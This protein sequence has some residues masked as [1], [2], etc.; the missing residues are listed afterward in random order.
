MK[1]DEIPPLLALASLL[2]LSAC[3]GDA[4]TPPD[5]SEPPTNGEGLEWV[6]RPNPVLAPSSSW[7]GLWVANASIIRSDGTFRM[8]HGGSDNESL[9]DPISIGY[10]TS[11]DGV[12]WTR[13]GDAPVLAPRSGM[14]D[15]THVQRPFV[16]SDGD[17][18][19]M[20]Y[21]GGSHPG[22]HDIGYATSTDG[23]VWNRRA[24]PVL[25]RGAATEWN[26]EFMS[27]GT[28][29]KEDGVFKMW[30]YSG[31]GL[32]PEGHW[33]NGRIE[34]GFATSPDGIAWTLYD[35]PET[36]EAPYQVSDPVLSP[37]PA[38]WDATVVFSPSVIRVL[39]GYEMWYTGYF[40]SG[41]S[42]VGYATSPDGIAWTKSEHNPVLGPPP[43]NVDGRTPGVI[44]PTVLQLGDRD[45]MWFTGW[46]SFPNRAAIG[47]AERTAR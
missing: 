14:W 6:H 3:S 20:W 4:I 39:E 34:I 19:R 43:W 32:A 12:N 30:F 37:G 38:G 46:A 44:F 31:S 29:I 7:D 27:P 13:F 17:T 5:D 1:S 22:D 28:V 8:W 16:L 15:H 11:S 33:G 9:A 45:L 10:A 25:V 36:T 47:L 35:D 24:E 21:G 42:R 18:L 40:P 2:L 26:A 23:I 41:G